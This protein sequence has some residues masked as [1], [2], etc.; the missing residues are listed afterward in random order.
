MNRNRFMIASVCLLVCIVLPARLFAQ[1][2]VRIATYNIKWLSNVNVNCGYTS[3]KDVRTQGD[4]L[5][6]LLSV[7][8]QLGADIIGLQEIRDREALELV[9]PDDEWTLVIDDESSDCQDLA[10]AVRQPLSIKNATDDGDLNAGPDEFLFEDAG[11]FAF[12]GSRDLLT[13]EVVLPDD[14][15]ELVIMV[16]HAKS[17]FDGRATT[18]ARRVAA[19]QQIVSEIE[20]NFDD[21]Y[22]V[23]LGDFN[24]NPDDASMNILETGNPGATA[25]MENQQGSFLINLVEPL[26]LTDTVS[27]GLKSNN[28]VNGTVITTDNGSR[29]RNFDF[30]DADVNTGDILFDQILVKPHVFQFYMMG[31]SAVFNGP[32]AVRGNN[33]TRA[34]DHAP[35]Y[36]DFV[37]GI[38]EPAESTGNLVISALL[39]NPQ[40]KDSGNEV[41][42]ITN[43]SQV[44]INLNGWKLRDMAGNTYAL[45]GSVPAG[46]KERFK[47]TTSSMPLNN[48]GDSVDL[49]D[50]DGNVRHHVSY[51]QSEVSNGTFIQFGM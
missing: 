36:A 28:I 12:P 13:V 10:L 5:E 38:G 19:A 43:D 41:V 15:G 26:L 42:E 39:P 51:D 11:S 50:S 48:S 4:R 25:L 2:P 45:S 7:I 30:R 47:M 31:S 8:E 37:F 16:H 35:V 46:Q 34:S 1:L 22:V 18:N 6:K 49:I 23:L 33:N 17:R 14:R 21:R 27:H 3:V 24:D 20:H 29:Q 32:D 44:P 9:F 40:G